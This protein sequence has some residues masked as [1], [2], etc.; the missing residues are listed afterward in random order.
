[1]FVLR[2]IK[3][4]N[5]KN[6]ISW[7]SPTSKFPDT[8]IADSHRI[9]YLIWNPLTFFPFQCFLLLSSSCK[10]SKSNQRINSLYLICL[11]ILK[12]TCFLYV[13]WVGGGK[14]EWRGTQKHYSTREPLSPS[15]LQ[16]ALSSH[17]NT[18]TTR[19]RHED[20]R[21][22]CK[23]LDDFSVEREESRDGRR[24]TRMNEGKSSQNPVDKQL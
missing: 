22:L 20:D 23:W 24:S 10:E 18:H 15:F 6:S 11:S 2:G 9:P 19:V 17:T 21:L 3:V 7:S 14:I 16:S 13:R 1:M 12:A 5:L 4:G 8:S